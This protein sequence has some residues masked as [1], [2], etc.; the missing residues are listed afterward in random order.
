MESASPSPAFDERQHERLFWTIVDLEPECV[1]LLS[2]DGCVQMMNRSGLRMVEADSEDQVV[3]RNM[4]CLIDEADHDAFAALV[5]RVFQGESGSLSFQI[6]GL[7]GGRRHLETHS[8]PLRD[9]RGQ[10]GSLLA[11]TRD[12][13]AQKRAIEALRESERKLRT[14]FNQATEGIFI[15]DPQ[16]RFLDVNPAG[17]QLTGYS[18]QE[19]LQLGIADLLVGGEVL[20]LSNEIARLETGNAITTEFH[21]QRKNGPSFVAEVTAKRLPDG[22]LQAFARDVTARRISDEALRESESRLRAAVRAG[23]VGLWDW[24]LQTGRVYFSS[25]WKHQVGHQD[26]EISDSFEEWRRRM[27]PDDL[28]SMLSQLQAF[29]S[30]DQPTFESEF[31]FRHKDGT[32]RRILSQGS[33]V[34]DA[35]G[36]PTRV[37][38]SHVDITERSELEAQFL[39]AQKMESIGR[40]AGGI[41]HDFNNLLTVINGMAE[42]AIDS[43][44]EDHPLLPGL[45]EIRLAGDRAARLTRQLLA[46]SR[47]QVLKPEVINLSHTVSG[48]ETMLRRLI[49][50]DVSLVLAL[51]DDLHNVKGDPGQVEQVILNLAVN[52]RD[53]MPDGG[54]LTIETANVRLDAAFAADHPSVVPG[55]HVRLTVSDTGDGM[56][57]ATKKRIF[58]PFFTTKGQGKGTGLGLSTVYGIVKQSGGSVWAAS[59]VGAGTRFDIYLPRVSDAVTPVATPVEPSSA[60]GHETI[61]LVEDERALRDLT[62]RILQSAG[63]IVI[64]ASN[65][66][67]ALIY[68]RDRAATR[69]DLMLTDVVMPGMNG[70]ELATRVE[71]GWPDIKVLYTSGYTDDEILRHGVLEDERRFIAKPYT[72]ADLKRK[73]RALLDADRKP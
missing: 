52:A 1:K 13:T 58:E 37:L 65:G 29:L 24:D 55:E 49:G 51:A 14:L 62:R 39:Q 8:V 70:R 46:L 23:R 68:L 48:M 44:G 18:R 21:L 5:E 25:E 35:G 2:R 56:D 61:L 63:Y 16:G 71:K 57:E 3:G 26:D 60:S 59:R 38:G 42:L 33:K 53:A 32:Y 31:R 41:A 47:Q 17:C 72:P 45:Q 4:C 50:E 15:S 7:K 27:H 43:I 54:T 9:D 73:V 66:D 34:L 69:V 20:R 40:L 64:E 10:I 28:P 22:T 6:T 30:S 19:L 11:V 36:Q 12:I 67:E